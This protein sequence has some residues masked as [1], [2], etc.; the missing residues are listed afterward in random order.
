V[1]ARDEVLARVRA[2]LGTT[3]R[4]DLDVPR[5]YR[6]AG[7]GQADEAAIVALFAERLRDYGA[8]VRT[9]PGSGAPSAVAAALADG[10]RRRAAGPPGRDG[11]RVVV[12]AG[13]DPDWLGEI[14]GDVI[15]DTGLDALTL[16]ACDA[17]VTA[18]RIAIAE[19]GT[20]VL[21]GSPDQGR[22]AITL[23]PD[24]HVCAVRAGQIVTGVPDAVALLDP[25]RPLTWVSGPSATS[26]IELDRVVGVHGP[27]T[28]EVVILA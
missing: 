5:A 19:T 25:A 4:A 8:G 28:L 9:A 16:D 15:R 26:D 23:V 12:P 20:I 27:R 6:L 14:A 21:D 7:Q 10:L 2:A 22:R 18:A 3:P 17:V 13:I 1:N 11:A 24:V